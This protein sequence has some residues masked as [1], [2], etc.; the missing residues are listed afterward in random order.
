MTEQLAPENPNRPAVLLSL[1]NLCLRGS[2]IAR[3]GVQDYRRLLSDIE[4][5]GEDMDQPVFPGRYDLTPTRRLAATSWLA[6]TQ[7]VVGMHTTFFKGCYDV[8]FQRVPDWR[9]MPGLER[10]DSFAGRFADLAEKE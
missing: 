7:S 3:Y 2:E 9:Y 8:L 6:A 5:N 10:S 1:T 4:Q